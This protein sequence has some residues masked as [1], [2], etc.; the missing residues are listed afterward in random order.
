MKYLES[1][2]KYEKNKKF[3]QWVIQN[4]AKE[5]YKNDLSGSGW[6]SNVNS[7]AYYNYA[8]ATKIA[9]SLNIPDLTVKHHEEV[10]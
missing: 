1:F 2:S 10:E 6:V 5:F 7:A 8:T 9:Q 3:N 4:S